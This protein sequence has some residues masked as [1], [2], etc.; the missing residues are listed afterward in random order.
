[1]PLNATSRAVPVTSDVS[2][3]RVHG[4][5]PDPWAVLEG[6]EPAGQVAGVSRR[7]GADEEEPIGAAAG[8]HGSDRLH[9]HTAGE[10]GQ[11]APDLLIDGRAAIGMVVDDERLAALGEGSELVEIGVLDRLCAVR[12]SRCPAGRMPL[13]GSAK[14]SRQAAVAASVRPSRLRRRARL[15]ARP[16]ARTGGR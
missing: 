13:S 6:G 1:M 7:G 14:I 15:A 2:R 10:V 4:E 16:P 3:A 12:G 8:A 11:P 9:G 5:F